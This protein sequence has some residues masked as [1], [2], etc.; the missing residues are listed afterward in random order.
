[1]L[2]LSSMAASSTQL[3]KPDDWFGHGL[4]LVLIACSMKLMDT[5]YLSG[6]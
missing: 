2:A 1:M 4:V 5:C 3:G 6:Q